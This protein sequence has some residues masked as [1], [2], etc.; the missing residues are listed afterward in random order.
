MNR[1]Q[2]R[3]VEVSALLSNT[4]PLSLRETGQNLS[5]G[6]NAFE[7]L[8]AIGLMPKE[9][10]EVPKPPVEEVWALPLKITGS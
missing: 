3:A 7:P 10:F 9:R 1:S 2:S 5:V 8:Q 6:T 4:V